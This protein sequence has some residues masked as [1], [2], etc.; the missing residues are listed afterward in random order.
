MKIAY[1][2][3][4]P[5]YRVD[6]VTRK[7]GYQFEA[8]KRAGHEAQ[9]FLITDETGDEPVPFPA[10][11]FHRKGNAGRRGAYRRFVNEIRDYQPDCVYLRWQF[12]RS[13]V[14]ALS[15]EFPVFVELNG[16]ILKTTRLVGRRNLRRRLIYYHTLLTHG[17]LFRQVAGFVPVTREVADLPYVRKWDKPI[18]VVPNAIRL[19]EFDMAPP[20][21]PEK[22][23]RIAFIGQVAPWH[24]VDK[25]ITLAKKTT[26][27]L[28][29]DLI[30]ADACD[31]PECPSNLTC[32]GYLKPE[33]Y[34]PILAGCDVGLDGLSLHLKGMYEACPLKIRE[35]VACGLPLILSCRETAFE[36]VEL[37]EW[38]L[39]ISNGPENIEESS[40]DIV[41]FARRMKG[42]RVKHSESAPYFD[43]DTIEERKLAF[44]I[45]CL[46][47]DTKALDFA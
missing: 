28:E 22:L 25:I 11:V 23:P 5:A 31:L 19:A 16:D 44:M 18:C 2:V 1:V 37:P 14:T 13:E 3:T 42:R 32:H 9:I 20:T 30:G 4:H 35:Y 8:W 17:I 36:G 43:V 24:G 34:L 45:E 12:H 38:V 29:I 39:Q 47:S 41:A 21:S 15:K 7:I 46:S 40:E 10:K 26:G 6:G 27:R 33:D